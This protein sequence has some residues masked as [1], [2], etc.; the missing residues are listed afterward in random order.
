MSAQ[1]LFKCKCGHKFIGKKIKGACSKCYARLEG[2]KL[3]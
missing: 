3:K 2:K 1:F